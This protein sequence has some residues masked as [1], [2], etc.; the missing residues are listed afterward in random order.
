MFSLNYLSYLKE[1]TGQQPGVVPAIW[2]RYDI[3]VKIKE[4]VLKNIIEI[5]SIFF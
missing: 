1:F 4:F 3:I 2:F 5:F